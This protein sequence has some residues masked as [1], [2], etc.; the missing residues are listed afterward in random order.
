MDEGLSG[1]KSITSPWFSTLASMQGAGNLDTLKSAWVAPLDG[2]VSFSPSQHLPKIHTHNILPGVLQSTGLQKVR[3]NL[4]TEQQHSP[5][6][7][8][9]LPLPIL[10]DW[11]AALQHSFDRLADW[12]TRQ[13]EERS[14]GWGLGF[15]VK[16]FPPSH[17]RWL[18]QP[19]QSPSLLHPPQI[20]L[21]TKYVLRLPWWPSE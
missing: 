11:K 6:P 7:V 2:P 5:S 8:C 1:L 10:E 19:M 9:S 20:K 4:A 3:H 12:G 16:N 21:K 17:R 15:L 18:S 13:Q 14:V